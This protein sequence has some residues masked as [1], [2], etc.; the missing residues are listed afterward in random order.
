MKEQIWFMNEKYLR[1]STLHGH[2][3]CEYI[4]E[5]IGI[6]TETKKMP[7]KQGIHTQSLMMKNKYGCQMCGTYTCYFCPES[8]LIVLL[9]YTVI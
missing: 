4:F 1:L 5:S 3:M 7:A 9:M 8:L 2:Y 6:N